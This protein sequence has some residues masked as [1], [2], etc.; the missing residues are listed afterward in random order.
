[1]TFTE[2]II[3]KQNFHQISDLAFPG[4][5]NYQIERDAHKVISKSKQ[6][7]DLSVENA[8]HIDNRLPVRNSDNLFA[9]W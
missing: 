7:T 9:T 5:I 1:M 6:W 8:T 3:T 2:R 4:Y